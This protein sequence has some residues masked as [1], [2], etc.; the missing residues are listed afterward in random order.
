[1][2]RIRIGSENV[3]LP[4]PESIPTPATRAAL[5]RA[6]AAKKATAE[7]KEASG[8]ADAEERRARNDETG[9]RAR[10]LVAGVDPGESPIAAAEAAAKEARAHVQA[11]LEVENFI[12]REVRAAV[13]ADK[14]AWSASAVSETQKALLKLT[15]AIRMATE[16][17]DSLRDNLGML[18]MY[19]LFERNGG[20]H[21]SLV[22]GAY[23][24]TFDVGAGLEMLREG[25]SKASRELEQ[26]KPLKKSKKAEKSSEAA[27]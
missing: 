6:L 2:S 23:T 15:T 7:A 27:E 3:N 18:G 22:V 12:A 26:R 20:G 17:R 13:V 5:E 19:Q 1:M 24:S 21:L 16:A 9:R 8:A 25:L 4:D 11:C 10:A 14:E